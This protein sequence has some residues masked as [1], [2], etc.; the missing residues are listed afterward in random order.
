MIKRLF[1]LNGIAILAVICNHAAGWGFTAMFWWAHRYLPGVVS[2]NFDQIGT[3]SYYALTII[4]KLTV[5]S[6][7]AFLFVSGFFVAYAA[8]GSQGLTWKVITTRITA[9]LIPYFIWSLVIF[10]GEWLESCLNSCQL[11]APGD[12]VTRLILGQATGAYYYVPLICEFYLLASFLTQQAKTRWRLLLFAAA[13]IQLST[14]TLLYLHFW[15]VDVPGVFILQQGALF[16]KTIF[17]FTFGIVAGF[18]F[19]VLAKWLAQVKWGLLAGVVIFGI[20]AVVEGEALYRLKFD[21]GGYDTPLTTLYVTMF[22]LAFLAFDNLVI[23]YSKTVYQ[24]GNKSYG[25]YLLHPEVLMAASRLIYHLAPLLLAY[26]LFYQPLLIISGV[27][28]PFWLMW[29]I[30][31]NSR[32]RNSYRYLF[33]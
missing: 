31:N 33:G 29:L 15:G 4:K 9:L 5:F 8:R 10:G 30:A 24:L 7:P 21:D 26:Q 19:S 11:A 32:V 28:I 2:P 6:V 1:L 16:T 27:G 22:V 25:L 23:P 12:Y 13:I 3:L 17:Y 20:A 18:H 14:M